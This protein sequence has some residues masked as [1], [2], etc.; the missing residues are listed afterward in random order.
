VRRGVHLAL[1][2]VNIP[3]SEK[4]HVKVAARWTDKQRGDPIPMEDNIHE[5]VCIDKTDCESLGYKLENGRWV[6]KAR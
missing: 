1:K 5:L 2:I 6:E 3:L 4:V